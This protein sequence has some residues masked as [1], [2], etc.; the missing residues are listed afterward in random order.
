MAADDA[1]SAGHAASLAT[2]RIFRAFENSHPVVDPGA[3]AKLS[4]TGRI[5]AHL[6]LFDPYRIFSLEHLDI[7][8]VHAAERN[9]RTQRRKA[10]TPLNGAGPRVA[11]HVIH[12][13]G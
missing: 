9:D 7:G 6:L 2:E 10:V 12:H 5:A 1:E 4:R 13:V 3:T 11:V 8:N